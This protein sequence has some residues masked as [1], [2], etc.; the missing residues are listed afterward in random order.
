MLAIERHVWQYVLQ[1]GPHGWLRAN[2]FT[3]LLCSF[4]HSTLANVWPQTCSFRQ[5]LLS[6][7]SKTLQAVTERSK[8]IS[9][10]LSC[11]T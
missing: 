4:S 1:H 6:S 7:N 5:V 11:I 3:I 2:Q 9:T 8:V 10:K